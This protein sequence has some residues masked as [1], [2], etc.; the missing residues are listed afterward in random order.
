MS[1]PT[2]ASSGAARA[3]RCVSGMNDDVAG[4][5]RAGR[6]DVEPELRRPPGCRRAHASRLAGDGRRRGDRR[7]LRRRARGGAGMRPLTQVTGPAAILDRQDVDTDQIIPKQFLKRIERSGFGEFLFY[8]WMRDP[9]VRATAAGGR[10][11]DD[12]ARPARTSAAARRASMRRGR[13]RTTASAII[14]APSYADIFRTNC[15]KTGLA[16]IVVPEADLEQLRAAVRADRELTVD[17]ETLTISHA[18]GL[19]LTFA[20]DAFEQNLLR[21]RPRRCRA[22]AG[23][24]RSD[25]RVRSNTPRPLRRPRRHRGVASAHAGPLARRGG[26]PGARHRPCAFRR[27]RSGANC[28]CQARVVSGRAMDGAWHR[29]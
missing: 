24:S 6:V 23:E 11:R 1:S 15:V 22:D 21:E 13:S 8:D 14:L 28:R 3:A 20:F 27:R 26:K 4:S 19:E 7:P 10:R 18:S 12:P 16:P 29:G 5:G 2:P 9:G 17:L 25:R